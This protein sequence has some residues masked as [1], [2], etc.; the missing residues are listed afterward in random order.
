MIRNLGQIAFTLIIAITCGGCIKVKLPGA[1]V[2]RGEPR[3]TLTWR[4]AAEMALARNPDIL[5]ARYEVEARD[6]ARKVAFG[7]YL[8]E[9]DGDLSRGREKLRGEDTWNNDLS[10]GV[11]AN[12]KLFTGF[13][14][15]GDYL[16]AKKAWEAAEYSYRETS[17]DVRLRLRTA[18]VRLL[19]L[20]TSLEV[21]TRIADRRRE[22]ADFI[23]LRYKSGRENLGSL[24]RTEAIAEGA[25][26]DVRSTRREIES[27]R[28]R[29]SR[30]MGGPFNLTLSIEDVLDKMVPEP[31]PLDLDYPSLAENSPRVQ[32]LIKTAEVFK[33]AIV[34][35][36]SA[37]WPK[38]D[39]TFIYDN[40]GEGASDLEDRLRIALI[41]TVP[42]FRGGKNIFGIAQARV[43]YEAALEDARSARDERT[44]ELAEGWTSFRDAWEFVKVSEAFMKAGRERARIV[45]AKYA[46]GLLDFQ[47]FDIAEQEL[48]NSE[49]DYVLSLA[50]VLL[51]QAEWEALKGSTLEEVVK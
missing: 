30:E 26:F 21:D 1:R 11:A 35:A 12:Q 9:A 37:V 48:A 27:Q 40:A 4:R 42:F 13:K 44:A 6:R 20:E 15:T 46:I 16:Q 31:P 14:T 10:I 34:S 29:L 43:E 3:S 50:D 23:K 36:Q 41:A 39:G 45:R 19:R 2:I 33:A 25:D 22:N 28:W 38:A 5:R 24:M 8:P 32:R 7:D 51:R 47:D 18:Y 49:R 17:A